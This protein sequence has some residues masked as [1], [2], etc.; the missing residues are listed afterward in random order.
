[1]NLRDVFCMYVFKNCLPEYFSFAGLTQGRSPINA[2]TV[3][4]PLNAHLSSR[5][6]IRTGHLRNKD[7]KKGNQI[8]TNEIGF[9]HLCLS[10]GP[11]E[12][13][14]WSPNLPV[15]LLSPDFQVEF[16]LPVSPAPAHWR[17]PVPVWHLPKGFQELKQPAETQECSSW[18][19]ALHVLGV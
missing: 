1:M 16:S 3:A 19:Q 15:P 11:S 17:V 7:F 13:P 9:H 4:K 18:S 5:W 10:L 6:D 12:C 8:L 14:H 2:K